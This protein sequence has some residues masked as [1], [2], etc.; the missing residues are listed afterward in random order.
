LEAHKPTLAVENTNLLLQ[1]QLL[2]EQLKAHN[3]VGEVVGALVK[4]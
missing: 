3:I 2:I 4:T 1:Q